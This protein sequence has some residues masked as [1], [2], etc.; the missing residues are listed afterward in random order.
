MDARKTEV[1]AEI[2]GA[3]DGRGGRA[4]RFNGRGSMAKG[5]DAARQQGQLDCRPA[6]AWIY[7]MA[8]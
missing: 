4:A 8:V 5:G 6:R 3:G 7:K 1:K 2:S